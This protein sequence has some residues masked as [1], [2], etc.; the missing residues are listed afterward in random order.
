M[1]VP[2]CGLL[3]LIL[4][5]DFEGKDR[6]ALE[7]LKSELTSAYEQTLDEGVNPLLALQTILDWS[8]AEVK[9]YAGVCPLSD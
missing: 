6:R 7:I 2:D 4:L 3:P 8:S 9:R 5:R 1:S